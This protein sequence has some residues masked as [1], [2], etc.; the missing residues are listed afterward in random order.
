MTPS[1]SWLEQW[2]ERL[3]LRCRLPDQAITVTV[4][5]LNFA[6]VHTLAKFLGELAPGW[7]LGQGRFVQ[8]PPCVSLA[9]VATNQPRILESAYAFG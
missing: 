2:H 8:W 3:C 5:A 6:L 9:A 1:V 4:D 7:R